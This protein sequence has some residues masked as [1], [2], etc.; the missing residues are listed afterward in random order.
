MH[1]GLLRNPASQFASGWTLKQEWSNPFFVAAPFRVLGL[2]QG[3]PEATR[4][5]RRM[6]EI[7]GRLLRPINFS[8]QKFL[9]A[10]IEASGGLQSPIAEIV[11]QK[12]SLADEISGQWRY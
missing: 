6:K 8:A 3:E 1:V 9:L 4:N 10:Q 7:D 5:A 12:L 2:N 11:R